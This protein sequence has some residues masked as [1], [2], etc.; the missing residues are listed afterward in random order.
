M[1]KHNKRRNKPVFAIDPRSALFGATEDLGV[2]GLLVAASTVSVASAVSADRLSEAVS[3]F[4]DDPLGRP[5]GRK[6]ILLP[7][8]INAGQP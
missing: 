5:G 3:A 1:I 2:E 8:T 4:S 7:S 6:S